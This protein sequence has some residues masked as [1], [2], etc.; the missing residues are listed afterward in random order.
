[1]ASRKQAKY[2]IAASNRK[3]GVAKKRILAWRN[4]QPYGEWQQNISRKN[5]AN[6]DSSS[7]VAEKH[8]ENSGVKHHEKRH[9]RRSKSGVININVS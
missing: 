4:Q 5:V 9:Q 3:Y 2:R 7:S 1:M 6:S 8:S